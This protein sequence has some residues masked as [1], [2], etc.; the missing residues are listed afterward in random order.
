MQVEFKVAYHMGTDRRTLKIRLQNEMN[1]S[2][3]RGV[4][5]SN[6]DA[7][8]FYRA[9]ALLLSEHH[10]QGDQVMYTDTNLDVVARV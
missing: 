3:C 2:D 9:V 5:F 1:F 6:D 4:L 7:G 10:A 8:A